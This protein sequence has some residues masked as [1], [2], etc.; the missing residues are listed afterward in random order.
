MTHETA[1]LDFGSSKLTVL[2]G[3]RGV[4]GTLTIKAIGSC[5]Y[6]GFGGGEW[7]DEQSVADAIRTS[8]EMATT[9]LGVDIT[10]LYVGVPGEFTSVVTK[11][12]DLVLKKRRKIKETDID[13][14]MNIGDDF[15]EE[16]HE[17]IHIQPVYYSL[18]N[19][20]C[21]PS[22][23]GVVSSKLGGLLSYILAEKSFTKFVGSI[24][25]SIG[26]T[27]VDFVSSVL[28]TALLV[29]DEEKRD[30]TAVLVD[31]GY[32]TSSVSVVKGD[33]LTSLSSFSLGGG[34]ITGDLAMAFELSFKD[35]EKLKRKVILSLS[36]REED[37]YEITTNS[38]VKTFSAKMVNEIV[39]YRIKIIAKAVKKCLELSGV[40]YPE[41]I[42]Y[43]LTG[44]GIAFIRG[45]KDILS[46]ELSRPIEIVA[47]PM[48]Q[49]DKPNL[50]SAWGV[51]DLAINNEKPTKKGFF[52]RLFN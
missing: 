48:P 2:I 29:F 17:V 50:S 8:I 38:G 46:Q 12:V 31:V 33:G 20:R 4:N 34:N 1:I 30:A 49:V 23:V 43:S 19:D 25:E 40:N 10:H 39:S 44:G 13:E 37:L 35:A 52:A 42:P 3:E 24:L 32:I 5:E 45:V 22:A 21:V 27:S 28:S 11:D 41:H 26:I 18:D 14:L 7:Y 16:T 36:A 15:N 9:S 51:L 6:A 47:P